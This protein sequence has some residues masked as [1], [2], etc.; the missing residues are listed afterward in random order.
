MSLG[1]ENFIILINNSQNFSKETQI[2]LIAIENASKD[3]ALVEN[4]VDRIITFKL[5]EISILEKTNLSKSKEIINLA[6]FN[7]LKNKT[8]AFNILTNQNSQLTLNFLNQNSQIE[9][10]KVKDI[11]YARYYFTGGE[12]KTNFVSKELGNNLKLNFK[13]PINYLQ[14]VIG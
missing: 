9:I 11:V 5:R 2:E 4:N 3:R 8:I 13:I 1:H 10:Y 14:E 7:Y 6:L 12:T